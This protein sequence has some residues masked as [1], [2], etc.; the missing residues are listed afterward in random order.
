MTFGYRIVLLCGCVLSYLYGSIHC[1]F[2]WS[3]VCT[4]FFTSSF[5][6]VEVDKYRECENRSEIGQFYFSLLFSRYFFPSSVLSSLFFLIE[7]YQF[8]TKRIPFI[9]WLKC[10]L[11]NVL[12]CDRKRLYRI[13]IILYSFFRSLLHCSLLFL[14]LIFKH[15]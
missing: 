1:D 5:E 7:Y 10:A 4:V 13:N 14:S 8:H 11:I 12:T 2:C 6:I 15:M 3:I 9:M